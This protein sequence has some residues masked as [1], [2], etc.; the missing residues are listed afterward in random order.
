MSTRNPFAGGAS[1]PQ[2]PAPPVGEDGNSGADAGS[3]R[4][5]G[6]RLRVAP[7][8]AAD[9]ACCRLP[10]TDLGNAERWK[11]RFGADFRFCA[12]IGWF[13]W[14][15]RRWKLLSEE[16]DRLPARVMQSVFLTVRAIRNEAALVAASGYEPVIGL[17]D[18]ER[19][20]LE[21]W[22]DAH[23]T[24]SHDLYVRD[25]SRTGGMSEDELGRWIEQLEPMDVVL[26]K[27]LW[28]QKI[29]GWAKTSE[30]AGKLDAVAR[31][32]KSFPQVA[33][34]PGELDQDRLGYCQT[35]CTLTFQR[36]SG[37]AVS[38]ALVSG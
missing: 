3:G 36:Y 5:E 25:A 13:A 15:G 12:E 4:N 10:L 8:P 27:T 24:T 32:A 2:S 19:R 31:L 14:D 17:S 9:L 28:S 29:A 26:G 21:A 1:P 18:K 33:I 38:L 37:H 35:N 23:G 16:R 30:G 11:V 34:E 6:A 7:D 22:A 20:A